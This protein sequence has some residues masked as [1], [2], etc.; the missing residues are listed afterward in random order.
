MATNPSTL[1]PTI[2]TNEDISFWHTDS[3]LDCAY[4]SHY[5]DCIGRE[6]DADGMGCDVGSESKDYPSTWGIED[7]YRWVT[8]CHLVGFRNMV[9]AF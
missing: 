8:G 6:L 4:I 1:K 2:D 7:W 5:M 3:D 9:Q